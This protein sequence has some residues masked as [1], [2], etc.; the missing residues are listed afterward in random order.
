MG[1]ASVAATRES[2][3]AV[4]LARAPSSV[5]RSRKRSSAAPNKWCILA[6]RPELATSLAERLESESGQSVLVVSDAVVSGHQPVSPLNA[7]PSGDLSVARSV[8]AGEANVVD[9]RGFDASQAS[10][11]LESGLPEGSTWF[12]SRGLA[13]RREE[14]PVSMRWI[15]LDPAEP[16]ASSLDDLARELLD[17]SDDPVVAF[18]EGKRFVAV[19]EPA[20]T[21]ARGGN[22]ALRAIEAFKNIEP[23]LR[24]QRILDSVCSELAATLR[25]PAHA[26]A[27]DRPM[28]SFGLDSLMAIQLKN[29]VEELAGVS[30]SVVKM[31][32]GFTAGQLADALDEK[33]SQN[34]DRMETQNGV[35]KNG[36]HEAPVCSQRNGMATSFSV[37]RACVPAGDPS[38]AGDEID[39]IDA[40]SERELDL[41]IDELLITTDEHD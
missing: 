21:Q 29:R 15:D 6:D 33:L 8:C 7:F 37:E 17:P 2:N 11:R 1:I 40:L 34:D 12:I 24:R 23:A 14:M 18:R 13:G 36:Q 10:P 26:I 28:V 19:L 25:L 5:V 16:I 30:V 35:P 22:G 4:F 32:E 9:M 27:P 31:L 41:L 3:Q 38:G 39:G 20:E